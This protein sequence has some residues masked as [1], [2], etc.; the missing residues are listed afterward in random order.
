M[1]LVTTRVADGHVLIGN[2]R[3]RRPDR[4]AGAQQVV[5]GL[6]PEDASLASGASDG[7]LTLA[8]DFIEELGA[9]RLLHGHSEGQALTISVDPD[10]PLADT[11]PVSINENALHYFD[12]ESGR[13]L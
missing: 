5:V 3:M 11:V 13:R 8:V 1:N 4:L 7:H 2:G 9:E 10:T 12:V 6:R